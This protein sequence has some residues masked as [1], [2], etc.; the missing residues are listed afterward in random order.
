[1]NSQIA[2]ILAAALMIGVAFVSPAGAQFDAIPDPNEEIPSEIQVDFG[3]AYYE[4]FDDDDGDWE[5]SDVPDKEIE[6]PAPDNPQWEWG[7]PT[8]GPGEAYVGDNVWATN[9]DGSYESTCAGLASPIIDLTD[10][11]SAEVSIQHWMESDDGWGGWTLFGA[12]LIFVTTD[13]GETFDYIIPEEGYDNDFSFSL[14]DCFDNVSSSENA[15]G[16]GPDFDYRQ[17]T[18]DLDDYV[19]EEVQVVFAF[20]DNS[21]R[22]EDGWYLDRFATTIDGVEDVED[23]E[24]DDGGFEIMST[25]VPESLPPVGWEWGHPEVGPSVD[26]DR[27]MWATNLEGDFGHNE[28]AWIESEPIDLTGLEATASNTATLQ[29]DQFFRASYFTAGGVVQIGVDGEHTIIE[30]DDGYNQNPP[31]ETHDCLGEEVEDTG[32]YGSFPSSPGSEPYT[33]TADISEFLGEEIT[34]RY[35]FASAETGSTSDGWY[36]DEVIVDLEIQQDLPDLIE[37][38]DPEAPSAPPLMHPLW[39]SDGDWEYGA[40]TNDGPI[41]ELAFA[42]NIGGDYDEGPSCSV[43]ETS[44]DVPVSDGELT[45]DQWLRSS[46]FTAGG[47]IQVVD[48]EG[49]HNVAPEEGYPTSSTRSSLDDCLQHETDDVGGAMGGYEQRS[50][51]PMERWTADLSDWAGE[52]ISLR[53]VWGV[54]DTSFTLPGWYVNNMTLDGLELLPESPA[55]LSFV[56]D[57]PEPDEAVEETLEEL[58]NDLNAL[59]SQLDA[60]QDQYDGW[61]VGG[62]HISWAYDEATTGPEGENVTATNP[63]GVHSTD[64]YECSYVQSPTVPTAFMGEDLTFSM[65]H[66]VDMSVSSWLGARTAGMILISDDLGLTW[67]PLETE[68]NEH[69][70]GYTRMYDCFEDLGVPADGDDNRALVDEI[71]VISGDEMDELETLEVDLSDYED[72]D[73]LTVRMIFGTGTT[74]FAQGGWYFN[75]VN[76]GDVQLME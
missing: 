55:D 29:W 1:M 4:S 30:P 73:T 5:K 37:I 22:D 9:L 35:L 69:E 2:S 28:C 52:E 33:E 40:I 56:G 54:A 50:G 8:S 74:I 18:I 49:T 51:D 11:D 62:E 24:E 17:A 10:A 60:Q 38:P 57:L 12:G 59:F 45:W 19:G 61:T 41:G 71:G 48:D 7:E 58:Q 25:H 47:M 32:A 63:H 21:D 44:I 20:G 27:N 31:S 64:E 43:L 75:N 42:T 66:L 65:D 67:E 13:E 6:R 72:A 76:L 68:A 3:D 15:F 16:G 70:V 14:E 26:D 53:F 39:V 23:F 36:V 34:I 46:S